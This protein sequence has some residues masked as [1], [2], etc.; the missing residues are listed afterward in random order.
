M[1]SNMLYVNIVSE[2][3]GEALNFVQH[4]IIFCKCQPVHLKYV[5]VFTKIALHYNISKPEICPKQQRSLCYIGMHDLMK[6]RRGK[7]KRRR[8]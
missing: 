1:T 4:S 6:S 2:V 3:F 5:I 7:R 8:E